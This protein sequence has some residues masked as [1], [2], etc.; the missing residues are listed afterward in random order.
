MRPGTTGDR[1][2]A[3]RVEVPATAEEAVITALWERGT[4]GVQVQSDPPGTVVLT[5]YF[6]ERPGLAADL[7]SSLSALG[8]T[9]VAPAFIPDVDWVA[10]FRE[11]FRG[12]DAGG[13]HI[14]PAWEPPPEGLI[15]RRTLRMLPARAFGTGTH[16][17]T[18]LCLSALESLAARRRLGRVV[19]VGAG[20][21]ILAIAATYLGARPVTAID[22]DPDAVE[23]IQMHA[24]MNAADVHLVRG[25]GG[26][27]LVHGRFDVVLANLTAPLLLA[28]SDEIVALGAPSSSVV[29]AGFLREDSDHIAAAYAELGPATVRI[30]GEWAALVFEA[31]P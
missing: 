18:R 2:V 20:T 19:D 21:G 5:A 15:A 26:R 8:A 3:F 29:L 9:N 13:F 25:D 6:A 17:S 12:F 7:R 23:S 22:I 11:G 31:G 1:L 27:P 16:E 28:K 10:R 14:V 30:D 4:T 24:R